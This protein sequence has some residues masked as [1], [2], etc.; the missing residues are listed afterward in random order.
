MTI[1]KALLAVLLSVSVLFALPTDEIGAP[2][3]TSTPKWKPISPD[4]FK[5][6]TVDFED[7]DTKFDPNKEVPDV[8]KHRALEFEDA[9]TT[10][11]PNKE[12]KCPGTC[13][14]DKKSKGVGQ[15]LDSTEND[16]AAIIKKEG[17][18][19][20]E[21]TANKCCKSCDNQPK[22]ALPI[23][24]PSPTPTPQVLS[25]F[26]PNKKPKCPGTCVLNKEETKCE[27][28]P[29]VDCAAAVKK[30]GCNP[31]TAAQCCMACPTPKAQDGLPDPSLPPTPT[32]TPTPIKK[33]A[34]VT[35][36]QTTTFTLKLPISAS[37]YAT[38]TKT[39]QSDMAKKL[40]VKSSDVSTI[41]KG[42][43]M[44]LLN[45]EQRPATVHTILSES[46][47]AS[48]EV[49]FFVKTQAEGATHEAAVKAESMRVKAIKA[50]IAKVTA[51][52]A[53]VAGV[54]V[55]KQTVKHKI[56]YH[57]TKRRSAPAPSREESGLKGGTVAGIAVGCVFGGAIIVASVVGTLT[58]FG[59]I[60]LPTKTSSGSCF[61]RSCSLDSTAGI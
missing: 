2:T 54:T 25:D 51:G 13:P 44:V 11:D 22:P 43:E 20:T 1:L 58:Y 35:V 60:T 49:E 18:K 39:I 34:E 50:A 41:L 46:E 26:N 55:P 61:S 31:T 16:C 15:C 37:Y 17:G 42:A 9:D 12:V 30:N 6:R 57:V 40:S 59:K 48:S 53:K 3:L 8:F 36:S 47:K 4:V 27:N 52:T 5:H 14:L 56:V 29:K 23:P 38:H 24:T 7:S 28:D 10:F 19:C 45:K 21:E 32:P 33:K